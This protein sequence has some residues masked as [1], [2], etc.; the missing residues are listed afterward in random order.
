MHPL[1]LSYCHE[2]PVS[3]N[4]RH[5]VYFSQVSFCFPI[6]LSFSL[7]PASDDWQGFSFYKGMVLRYLQRP[8]FP[9]LHSIYFLSGCQV[10]RSINEKYED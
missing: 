2:E 7:L 6:T 5:E 1:D 3:H 9:I 8:L 4:D 10:V